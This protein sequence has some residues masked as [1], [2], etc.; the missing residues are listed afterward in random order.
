MYTINHNFVCI[1]CETVKRHNCRT[2][3]VCICTN[4]NRP[5]VSIGHKMRVPKKNRWK[6]F[7]KML[8]EK[9]WFNERTELIRNGENLK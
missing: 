8:M 3:M 5:M 4:C 1:D 6:A 9:N 7:K 2:D